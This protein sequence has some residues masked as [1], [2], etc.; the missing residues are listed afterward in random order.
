MIHTC[1]T[2]ITLLLFQLTGKMRSMRNSNTISFSKSLLM[3]QDQYLNYLLLF[4]SI[5][6]ITKTCLSMLSCLL[7]HWCMKTEQTISI[8]GALLKVFLISY[9][10][11]SRPSPNG[12]PLPVIQACQYLQRQQ[13]QRH[14]KILVY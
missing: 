6:E 3:V 10:P 8:I 7:W 5:L 12:S 11:S 2:C 13:N 4:S 9:L 1:E 14:L